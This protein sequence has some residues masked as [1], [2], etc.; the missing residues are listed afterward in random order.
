MIQNSVIVAIIL[1]LAASLAYAEPTVGGSSGIIEM[2]TAQ[3]L[4]YKEWNMGLSIHQLS[5]ANSS[6]K[7]LLNLGTFQG[8]EVGFVG[9]NTS[10]GVFINA[11][12]YLLTDNTKYPL[13][14]AL[15]IR[16][17]TSFA[18]TNVYLVASKKFQQFNAHLGF[19]A[20]LN[21]KVQSKLMA[22]T[23]VFFSKNVS[24]LAD[25]TGTDDLWR[26][27]AGSR[28]YLSSQLAFGVF[29]LDILESSKDKNESGSINIVGQISWTDFL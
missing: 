26:L 17:L 11:K 7:Y 24:L 29:F 21:K 16:N 23:E 10:E 5:S 27:N 12:F 25:V 2:P 28:F 22:G 14:M 20:D 19:S 4:Q 13:S 1:A 15:G 18:E 6:V 9:N 3:A 8:L